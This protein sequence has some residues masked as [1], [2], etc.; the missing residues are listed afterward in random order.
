MD[1]Y[2][3]FDALFYSDDIRID[4]EFFRKHVLTPEC[5]DTLIC[6][7][8]HKKYLL[9]W[10]L[11]EPILTTVLEN[12][13]YVNDDFMISDF[14]SFLFNKTP[15]YVTNKYENTHRCHWL[16][17]CLLLKKYSVYDRIKITQKELL[18]QDF[19]G[20]TPMHL[21][22]LNKNNKL[23]SLF[24]LT[25]IWIKNK[26]KQSIFSLYLKNK[27][28]SPINQHYRDYLHSI[29][30]YYHTP[31]CISTPI[32]KYLGGIHLSEQQSAKYK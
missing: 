21:A 12:K 23:V 8:H 7:K 22:L 4:L 30:T 6:F 27:Y 13:E 25:P 29:L 5:F 31:F 11:E 20:N 1:I 15:A 2:S 19:K 28:Y 24:S 9:Q 18:I 3:F 32:L 10:F 26:K 16:A 14:Y 17:N